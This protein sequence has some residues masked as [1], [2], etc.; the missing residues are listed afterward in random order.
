M[1][2]ETVRGE[3]RDP[4]PPVVHVGWNARDAG[5]YVQLA[6]LPGA[7]G[8]RGDVGCQFVDLNRDG[9]NRL[10]RALRRARDSA[11]GADA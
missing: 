1:P 9:I 10:I 4:A 3:S 7:G 5:G 6:T 2:K 11:F 8:D